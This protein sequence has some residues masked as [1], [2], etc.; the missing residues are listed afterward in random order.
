M[1]SKSHKERVRLIKKK[2]RSLIIHDHITH[3]YSC[4]ECGKKRRVKNK[5]KN[6]IARRHIENKYKIF[7]C[8]NVIFHF[9]EN[10]Y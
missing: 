6:H 2:I 9:Q 3:Y 1:M 7:A 8:N 10:I 4:K 5:L